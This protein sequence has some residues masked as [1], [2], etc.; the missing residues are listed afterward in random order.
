MLRHIMD[1]GYVIIDDARFQNEI[2]MWADRRFDGFN[3]S[4]FWIHL[5]RENFVSK[6]TIA[7]QEHPSENGIPTRN[8]GLPYVNFGEKVYAPYITVIT[9]W[10]EN[11]KN[12]REAIKDTVGRTLDVLESERGVNLHKE[13]YDL[14]LRFIMEAR[15]AN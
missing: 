11:A 4:A 13:G 6:E 14:L 7:A 5:D 15:A 10:A 2:S 3:I 8:D 1:L 9:P 12:G